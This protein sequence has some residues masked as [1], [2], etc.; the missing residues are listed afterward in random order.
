MW[1]VGSLTG[2]ARIGGEIQRQALMIG[3]VNAFWLYMA[4]SLAVTLPA[5][6]VR[7]GRSRP[8]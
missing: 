7:R 3:Y 1:D 4:A 8:A 5:L 6:L 2:L